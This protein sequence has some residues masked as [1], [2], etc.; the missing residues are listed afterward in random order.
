LTNIQ[1]LYD[2]PVYYLKQGDVVYVEPNE[3]KAR[4]STGTGNAFMQPTLWISLASLVTTI[5]VLIFK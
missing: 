2:S 4:E 3:K 1:S 5:S